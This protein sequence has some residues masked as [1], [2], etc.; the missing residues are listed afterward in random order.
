MQKQRG[1]RVAVAVAE[2]GSCSSHS[3]SSL[4]MSMCC[5]GSLKKKKKD[6]NEVS[7]PTCQNGYYEKTTSLA[8][9]AEKRKP[10]TVDTNTK[11]Y[12]PYG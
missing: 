3:T 10:Y 9:D 4:G 12:R 11:W 1:S 7:P 5:T 2:A 6:H 8:E